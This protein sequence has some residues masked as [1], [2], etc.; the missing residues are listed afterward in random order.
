MPGAESKIFKAKGWFSLESIIIDDRYI[1]YRKR[2]RIFAPM[3][4]MSIPRMNIRTVEFS[5]TLDGYIL[6]IRTISNNNIFSRGF[7]KR[8]ITKIKHL[9]QK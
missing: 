9:L 3:I 1:T 7:S 2:A 6:R 4:T 8:D 5:R